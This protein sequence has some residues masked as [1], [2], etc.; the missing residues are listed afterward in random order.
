MF[1][2]KLFWLIIAVLEAGDC[3][4]NLC[5]NGGTCVDLVYSFGCRCVNGYAGDFCSESIVYKLLYLQDH[6]TF[7]FH[8]L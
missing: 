2:S 1:L 8:C 6:I 4:S 3:D 7:E 5:E